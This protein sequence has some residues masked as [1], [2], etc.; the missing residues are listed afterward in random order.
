MPGAYPQRP[1]A[2]PTNALLWGSLALPPLLLPPAPPQRVGS[3][4]RHLVCIG[5]QRLEENLGGRVGG[6][7]DAGWDGIG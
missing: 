1:P 7:L 5:R 4:G 3:R 2:G 6:L